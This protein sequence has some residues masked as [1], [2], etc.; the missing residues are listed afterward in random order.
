[1]ELHTA[2]AVAESFFDMPWMKEITGNI[3]RDSCGALVY[4]LALNWP[5]GKKISLPSNFCTCRNSIS[6]CNPNKL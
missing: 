4:K 3:H 5:I 1:M 6:A 2:F